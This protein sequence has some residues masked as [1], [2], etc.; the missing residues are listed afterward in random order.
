MDIREIL[1]EAGLTES[2][3]LVYQT[4]LTLG[5]TKSGAIIEHTKLQSS[6]VFLSLHNLQ[7]KGLVTTVKI[8]KQN[9]YGAV[10]P[11][12]LREIHRRRAERFEQA[13]PTLLAQ[14]LATVSEFAA[15]YEDIA[16]LQALFTTLIEDA[17]PGEIIR[18][19]DAEGHGQEERATNVYLNFQAR[20]KE[21][22]LTLRGIQRVQSSTKEIYSG[23]VDLRFTDESIPPDTTIFRDQIVLV[24]WGRV[25]KGILI[26][27][28][29]LAE[30]YR[31]LWDATWEKLA[32]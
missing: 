5:Q 1:V 15:L 24:S 30:Q 23:R 20:V 19:F 2:E 18:Y 28:P 11:V 22:R 29:E 26:R 8:G 21:K 7:D 25:P 31:K 27:S 14:R 10:S 13:L 4:L 9:R 17:K 32:K 12:A 3:G 16:G 6:V